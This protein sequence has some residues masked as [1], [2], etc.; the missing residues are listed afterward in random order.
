MLHYKQHSIV[1]HESHHNRVDVLNGIYKRMNS[2]VSQCVS[3]SLV[4]FVVL[5]SGPSDSAI[6]GCCALTYANRNCLYTYIL[7]E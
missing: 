6:A 3:L 5:A 7:L 2:V 4:F 1:E